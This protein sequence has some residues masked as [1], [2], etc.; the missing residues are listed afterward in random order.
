MSKRRR[1]EIAPQHK[2]MILLI[3]VLAVLLLTVLFAYGAYRK[4][5]YSNRRRVENIYEISA[6][7]PEEIAQRTH[8]LIREMD[9][10]EY[11][12]IE[13]RS[14]DGLRLCARYYHVADGAPLHI[15]FH[16][17]RSYAMRDFC[18]GNALARECGHNTLLVDQRAHGRSEGHTITFGIKERIDC[19][20]WVEYA[21]RRFG[22]E[23]PIFLSG[24]LMGAATVLMATELNLPSN[25]VGVIADCPYSSPRAIIRKVIGDMGLPVKAAYPF[26]CIGAWLFG[27]IRGL[28]RHGA[29]QAV[30]H[31]TVPIL[32]FHGEADDFVPCDMSREIE[33]ACASAVRLETFPDA[34]HAMCYMTDYDRYRQA[35]I[36]FVQSCLNTFED[37]EE[38]K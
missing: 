8:S 25:V 15:Q 7:T 19:L 33:K 5:F 37:K 12:P 9:G 30:K 31:A 27:G 6:K 22:T 10:R 1:G 13:I 16:G 24:V 32:L 4:T 3:L 23:T 29:V 34:D 20:R 2:H 14:D 36:A 11:E 38:R 28:S 26:V 35:T 21:T 18:G 17:Y